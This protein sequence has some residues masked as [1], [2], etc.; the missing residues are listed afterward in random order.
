MPS[1]LGELFKVRIQFLH[2]TYIGRLK[3]ETHIACRHPQPLRLGAGSVPPQLGEV[4][5]VCFHQDPLPPEALLEEVGVGQPPPV[6]S[7][8]LEEHAAAQRLGVLQICGQTRR[9]DHWSI[10]THLKVRKKNVCD[11]A[12]SCESKHEAISANL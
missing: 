10:F 12:W 9:L 8:H 1:Q 5:G 4:V 3:E 7:T 6:Q 11:T 2:T